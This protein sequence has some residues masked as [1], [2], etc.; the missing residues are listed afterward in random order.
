VAL[1]PEN[2]KYRIGPVQNV[3]RQLEQLTAR[4]ESLGIKDEL[5]GILT[6][7]FHGLESCPL[8]FG[9]PER[10]TKKPGGLVC[11]GLV[12]PISVQFAVYPEERV[13]LVLDIRAYSGPLT[14]A[15]EI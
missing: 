4:A 8:E 14:Q 10:A 13:V 11:H 3:K 15:G 5:A 12:R 7:V 6:Q 2:A 9:E 1:E